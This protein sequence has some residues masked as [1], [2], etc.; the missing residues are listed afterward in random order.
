MNREEARAKLI[1]LVDEAMERTKQGESAHAILARLLVENA[2]QIGPRASA[3]DDGPWLLYTTQERGPGDTYLWWRPRQS[4]YTNRI[5][6]AG[7]YTRKEALE[8]AGGKTARGSTVA[9]PLHA[10]LASAKRVVPFG[11]IADQL[12]G[13][14]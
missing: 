12:V 13:A 11:S 6:E 4:G 5:D 3:E 10:A 9:V 1:A 2:L 14:R 7:R 8:L